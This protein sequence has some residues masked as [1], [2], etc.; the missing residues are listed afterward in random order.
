MKRIVLFSTLTES[1]HEAVL[2]QIFPTNI[3]D[4]VFSYMPSGGIEGAEQYIEEWRETSLSDIVH[5]LT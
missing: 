1:N 2:S 3:Q 4:K 5:N